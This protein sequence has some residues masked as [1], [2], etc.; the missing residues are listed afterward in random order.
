MS[1]CL[2]NRTAAVS[3]ATLHFAPRLRDVNG[4]VKRAEEVI[5]TIL[6]FRLYEHANTTH[7]CRGVAGDKH[8]CG[9]TTAL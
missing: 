5:W 8:K 9:E 7:P 3:G 2:E 1:R 6:F 4:P